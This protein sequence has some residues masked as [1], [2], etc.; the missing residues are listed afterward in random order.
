[1]D[2]DTIATSLR[3]YLS[4]EYP[5]RRNT[6]VY[7]VQGIADG[8]ETEVFAFTLSF[9]ENDKAVTR[10]YILRVY[11]GERSSEK[12]TREFGAMRTLFES[13]YPV[14]RV[15]L[16]E[17]DI[18]TL[19]APFVVMQ[20]IDGRQ[21]GSGIYP[22][23][24][25]NWQEHLTRFCEILAVLHKLDPTQFDIFPEGLSGK[26]SGFAVRGW[27]G[28]A[29]ENLGEIDLTGFAPVLDWL[30]RNFIYTLNVA[31]PRESGAPGIYEK[32]KEFLR[33]ILKS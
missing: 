23:Q 5:D 2:T 25:E 22:S 11:P 21:L 6:V 26:D 9:E 20:K 24:S 30:D 13:G 7:D 4:E 3:K 12:A 18:A 32:S 29:R 1:M 27:L 17:T 28:E 15:Y 8:W 10:D 31:G 19:G 33:R 14:P 16:L